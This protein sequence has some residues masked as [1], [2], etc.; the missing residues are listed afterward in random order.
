MVELNRACQ[1][2]DI[3]DM[4]SSFKYLMIKE[5]NTKSF[6][7]YSKKILS[8]NQKNKIELIR[9]MESLKG[10]NNALQAESEKIKNDYNEIVMMKK[11]KNH[12]LVD[13]E[14]KI[15]EMKISKAGFEKE[16][17]EKDKKYNELE[18]KAGAYKFSYIQFYRL[19][20]RIIIK[21]KES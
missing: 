6:M 13:Y 4:I 16:L 20:I 2:K 8:L 10:Q 1:D 14:K 19:H 18:D 7:K 15:N 9:E 17:D 3:D 11:E 5:R 12:S 21:Q